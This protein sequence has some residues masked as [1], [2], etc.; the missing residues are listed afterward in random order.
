MGRFAA[1]KPNRVI[2]APNECLSM[3]DPLRP[4]MTVGTQRGAIGL[5]MSM[6]PKGLPLID[7]G[8]VAANNPY[9]ML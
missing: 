3:S 1:E 6:F 5:L 2:V 7:F 4:P 8:T 9:K